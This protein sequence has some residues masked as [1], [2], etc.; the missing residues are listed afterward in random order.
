MGCFFSQAIG[1]GGKVTMAPRNVSG[2][3]VLTTA[4]GTSWHLQIVGTKKILLFPFP[5]TFS[6]CRFIFF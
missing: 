5:S 1:E 2:L 3:P 6:L 4:L